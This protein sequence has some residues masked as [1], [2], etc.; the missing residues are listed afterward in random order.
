MLD[1]GEMTTLVPAAG[2]ADGDDDGGGGGGGTACS[3]SGVTSMQGQRGSC[4][5]RLRHINDGANA[6]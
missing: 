4:Q 1:G 3:A 6:P 2:A 5:G